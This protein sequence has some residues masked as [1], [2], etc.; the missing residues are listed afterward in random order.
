MDERE[1]RWR[2]WRIEQVLHL[3]VGAFHDLNDTKTDKKKIAKA[4]AQ[5]KASADKLKI[6]TEVNAPHPHFSGESNVAV[7]V[8]DDLASQVKANTDAEAAA[9]V[10]LNGIGARV[11]AAVQ[12]AI[13]NGATAEELAPVQ[14]EVD[15]LKA[16]ADALSAAIV[17]NTPS[18]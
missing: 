1:L 15:S 5:L 6:A 12:A 2:L 4:V 18:E 17:A 11:Q 14:A 16:S 9:V 7:K 8:L 10:V 3:L 13:A